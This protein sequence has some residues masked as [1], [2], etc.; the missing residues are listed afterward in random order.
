MRYIHRRLCS[1]KLIK[2][3][4]NF[5]FR[6]RV[7]R[8]RRFVQHNERRFLINGSCDGNFLRFTAGNF[9]SLIVIIFVKICLQPFLHGRETRSEI[10]V[11]Q[12]FSH[13]SAVIVS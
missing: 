12:A 5:I 2:V 8:R 11:F 1:R 10:R 3:G 6:Q 13:Q 4:I 7:K 9:D